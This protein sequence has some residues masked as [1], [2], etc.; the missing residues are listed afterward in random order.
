VYLHIVTIFEVNGVIV[1][2]LQG[3]N[4]GLA[5]IYPCYTPVNPLLTPCYTPAKCGFEVDLILTFLQEKKAT[6]SGLQM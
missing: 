5:G 1:L 4:K 3:G 2:Y 6:K